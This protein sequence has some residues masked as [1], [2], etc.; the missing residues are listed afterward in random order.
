MPI[1]EY[2]PLEPRKTCEKCASRFEAIQGINEE[3]LSRCTHC[4]QR[5]RKVISMCRSMIG[6]NPSVRNLVNKQISKYERKGMWSHAAELADK[7]SK[8]LGDPDMKNNALDD[9][10]KAGYDVETLEKH[11][12]ENCD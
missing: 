1:Y 4:G 11:S 7:Q 3:P 12:K 6:E 2:E 8:T 5:V 9:Y 10:K